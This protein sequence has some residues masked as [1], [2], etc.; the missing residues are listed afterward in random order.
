M[1]VKAPAR[2]D[3]PFRFT[4]KQYYELGKLGY[5]DGKRVELIYGEIVEMSPTGWPHS[6]CVGLVSEVLA[7]V[8]AT[9]FWVRPQQPFP[10]TGSA[11]VSEP[12]PDVAVIPGKLRDYTDHP[13]VAALLV[14]VADATLSYDLTTKAEM[15][16]TANVPEYWVLD[17]ENRALHVFRDPAPLQTELEATA[18]QTHLTL[19]PADHASP[20]AAPNVSILV[21]DLLP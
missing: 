5:F 4:L 20:L 3:R 6:L 16:A 12:E 17:V 21:S 8:F 19:S 9:G 1:T 14:E 2:P 10:I 13:T 15:Y 18:Y 11:L 7:Q